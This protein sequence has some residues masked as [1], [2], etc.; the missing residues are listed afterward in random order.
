MKLSNFFFFKENIIWH[1]DNKAKIVNDGNKSQIGNE[2][3]QA[4]CQ[5]RRWNVA[6]SL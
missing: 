3:F 4:I 6:G 1:T 2:E 5:Y